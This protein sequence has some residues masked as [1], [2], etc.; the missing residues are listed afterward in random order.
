MTEKQLIHRL[1]LRDTKSDNIILIIH[2][3][4]RCVKIELVMFRI[5]TLIQQIT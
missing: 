1:F 2:I 5:N 4:I 3:E